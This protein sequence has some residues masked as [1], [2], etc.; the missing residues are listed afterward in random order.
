MLL[1]INYMLACLL[2]FE[3]IYVV[4]VTPMATTVNVRF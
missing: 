4:H 3:A 1:L 2:I